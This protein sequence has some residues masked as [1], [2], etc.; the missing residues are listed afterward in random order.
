MHLMKE[1]ILYVN[2][3]LFFNIIPNFVNVPNSVE[4]YTMNFYHILRLKNVI[5]IPTIST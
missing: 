5:N 4:H 2:V 1:I 3:P